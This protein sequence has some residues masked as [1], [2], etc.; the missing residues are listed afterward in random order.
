M[1]FFN[2]VHVMCL[3]GCMVA[4]GGSASRGRTSLVFDFCIFLFFNNRDGVTGE[5]G[6]KHQKGRKISASGW[7][8]KKSS[9]TASSY[10]VTGWMDGSRT[11]PRLSPYIPGWVF[12]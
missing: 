5:G 1:G 8:E 6:G 4:S 12:H 11:G 10:F 9:I 2:F 3:A 7:M